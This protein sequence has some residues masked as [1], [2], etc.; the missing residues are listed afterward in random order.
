MRACLFG[1]ESGQVE[2]VRLATA[3]SSVL[4]TG[5][6]PA[7]DDILGGADAQVCLTV[8]VAGCCCARGLWGRLE[9][10]AR[11]DRLQR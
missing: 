8:C 9:S 2:R 5:S 6:W 7:D 1:V 3:L 11:V 10:C 4:M